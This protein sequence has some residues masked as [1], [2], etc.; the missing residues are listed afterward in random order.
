MPLYGLV[1]HNSVEGLIYGVG[2]GI[3]ALIASVFWG[4]VAMFFIGLNKPANLKPK[5]SQFLSKSYA[6]ISVVLIVLIS[7]RHIN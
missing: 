4:Y 3:A 5:A 1:S 7:T 2:L 6:V